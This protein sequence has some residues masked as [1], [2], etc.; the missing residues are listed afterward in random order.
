ML[1]ALLPLL[2]ALGAPEGH[3]QGRGECPVGPAAGPCRCLDWTRPAADVSPRIT[4]DI[5]LEGILL[6][7]GGQEKKGRKKGEFKSPR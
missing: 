1:P 3:L 2:S 5:F 4:Q 6:L 7:L